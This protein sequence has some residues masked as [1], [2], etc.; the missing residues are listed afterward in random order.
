MSKMSLGVLALFIVAGSVH[1]SDRNDQTEVVPST[2]P[3]AGI[4]PMPLKSFTGQRLGPIP[5]I[6]VFRVSRDTKV[7]AELA[8]GG[9]GGGATRDVHDTDNTG[10]GG[11]AGQF[12]FKTQTLDRGVYFLQVGAGGVGGVSPHRPHD[13]VSGTA[14]GNTILGR[15][16]S[17]LPL[18]FLQGGSGGA[19]D[20]NP[21][22]D[23]GGAG[24]SLN[25][26]LTGGIV[27]TGG[28]GGI[29]QAD[30]KP[31]G[32][33]GAGGGGQGGTNTPGRKGGDGSPG[34]AVLS[35][36]GDRS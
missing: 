29:W 23:R 10:A 11:A 34:Y 27:G 13:P 9:G 35:L 17:G 19:G 36:I 30:G 12:E 4:R 7:D 15:C 6:R 28:E 25:N 26:P 31:A 32:G 21:N 14:G 20:G 18:T 2:G 24:G 5:S 3:C 8:S 1:A 22:R 16:A 33:A